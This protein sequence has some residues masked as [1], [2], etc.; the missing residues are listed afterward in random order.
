MGKEFFGS[1]IYTLD[2]KQKEQENEQPSRSFIFSLRLNIT[3]RL[4]YTINPL[5]SSV[6]SLG[7][8]RAIPPIRHASQ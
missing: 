8:S 5:T 1:R 3:T 4:F 6:N 2:T 7:S